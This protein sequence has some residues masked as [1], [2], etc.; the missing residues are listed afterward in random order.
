MAS[1]AGLGAAPP[2][3]DMASMAI[4]EH[5]KK[6]KRAPPELPP[7][8]SMITEKNIFDRCVIGDG[9]WTNKKTREHTGP[10]KIAIPL[11]YIV[12]GPPTQASLGMQAPAP[13]VTVYEK[14]PIVDLFIDQLRLLLKKLSMKGYCSATKFKCRQILVLAH[15]VQFRQFY[16]RETNLNSVSNLEKKLSSEQGA[17]LLSPRSV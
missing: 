13:D 14:H 11:K 8:L 6:Q 17:S 5:G 7:E 1:S 9:M 16:N 10:H 2:L 4:D 15:H 12:V 3:K